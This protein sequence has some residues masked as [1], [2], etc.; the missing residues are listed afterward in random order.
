MVS[1]NDVYLQVYGSGRPQG[2]SLCSFGQTPIKFKSFSWKWHSVVE[3]DC[4]DVCWLAGSFLLS[5]SL[6]LWVTD[7][8]ARLFIIHNRSAK[9]SYQLR[10]LHTLQLEYFSDWPIG[11]FT[12][13]WKDSISVADPHAQWTFLLFIFKL[14]QKSSKKRLLIVVE[15][16]WASDPHVTFVITNFVQ[17][18]LSNFTDVIKINLVLH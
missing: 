16:L 10:C 8:Q 12:E 15:N 11:D 2:D 14:F 4:F 1:N 5:D 13:Q 6:D 18:Q 3:S 9:S 7:Q 17:W